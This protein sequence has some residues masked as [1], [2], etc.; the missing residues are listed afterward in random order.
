MELAEQDVRELRNGDTF[1]SEPVHQIKGQAVSEQTSA[2]RKACFHCGAAHAPTQC[3]FRDAECHH[4]GK[5]GHIWKVCRSRNRSARPSGQGKPVHRT[6]EDNPD[7]AQAYTLYSIRD[8]AAKPLQTT[9]TVEDRE[10]LMEV[11]TGASVTVI[12]KATLDSIWGAQQSPP[13]QPTDVKLRTYT[14]AEIPVAGGLEV[15]V[16][17]EGQEEKLP[18]IVTAGNGPSLIGRDWLTKLTLDWKNIVSTN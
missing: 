1:H 12:S 8:P 2:T 9:V 6:Q 7:Q 15:K 5:K 11:D 18:L 17:Y 3:H 13:L 10:I 16:Q 14:G 4:C